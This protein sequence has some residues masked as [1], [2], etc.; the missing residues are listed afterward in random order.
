ML[1]NISIGQRI[2]R[3]LDT[4]GALILIADFYNTHEP[5]S[6]YGGNKWNHKDNVKNFKWTCDFA[7]DLIYSCGVSWQNYVQS[8]SGSSYT[9]RVAI[10]YVMADPDDP[11]YQEIRRTG[12]FVS[13]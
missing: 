5:T 11:I 12:R 2:S 10:A 4:K 3:I 7:Q 1:Q 8:G 9:M 13:K 6:C